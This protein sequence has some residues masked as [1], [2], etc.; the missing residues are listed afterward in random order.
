MTV[1]FYADENFPTP[2]I[3]AVRKQGVDI[4]TVIEDNRGGRPDDEI[5]SRATELNRVVLTHDH[6]FFEI[7][8]RWLDQAL[9]YS[10]VCFTH[11][12]KLSYRELIEE[13]V[14]V[15]QVGEPDDFRNRLVIIPLRSV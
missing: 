11:Q 4:T 9:P 14:F 2:V 10:G 1:A 6:D 3:H 8:H 15:S 7:V 5:L 13:L 12:Q